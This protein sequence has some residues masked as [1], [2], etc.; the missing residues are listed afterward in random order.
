[1]KF[2]ECNILTKMCPAGFELICVDGQTEGRTDQRTDITEIT[3][4]FQN[5]LRSRLK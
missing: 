4:V 5:I 3:V 1:M 2:P